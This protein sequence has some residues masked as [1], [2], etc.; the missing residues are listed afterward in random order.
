[1]ADIVSIR[2]FEL[3]DNH[4]IRFIFSDGEDKIINFIQFIKENGTLSGKLAE[5]EYFK[6]V[7]L[8]ES[9]AG[10]YWPDGYDFCPEYLRF[11]IPAINIKNKQLN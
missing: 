4:L 11:H 1:M 8:Y 6:K 10:I 2:K 9:G 5:P 7:R 3:L